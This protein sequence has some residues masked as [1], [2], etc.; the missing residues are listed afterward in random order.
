MRTWMLAPLLY[1]VAAM[2][3][4]Q[5]IETSAQFFDRSIASSERSN[6]FQQFEQVGRET[7]ARCC[8]VCTKGKP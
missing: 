1:A 2:G 6:P 5:G 8:K 3:G 4:D 7:A